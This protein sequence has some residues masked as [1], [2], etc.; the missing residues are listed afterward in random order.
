MDF[1]DTHVHL[2]L[3]D[4]L[5]YGWTSDIPALATGD[6]TL[7]DYAGLTAGK[8][9]AGWVFMETG[10][11]DADYK[12][13]ARLVSGL[14]GQSGLMGL[15]ASCRPED[16]AGFDDWLTECDGLHVH[17]Y[18]RILH[19]M[20]DDLSQTATFRRNVAKIGARGL[21]FDVCVLARQLPIALALAKA[22]PGQ[23]LVLD[24]CGVPDI[25]GGA[26]D[27]WARGIDALA[28]LPQ[29]HLKLSGISANC[30]PGQANLATLKPWVDHAIAAFGAKRVLWGG[31]W[32]VVNLGPGLPDW[33]D[34]SRALLADLSAEDQAQ[35]MQGTA[36]RVYRLS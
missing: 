5:G 26:F 18:R 12:A 24:H 21:P 9:V 19:V 25:A 2:I 29:M 1:I 22:C 31:D 17:G 34:L 3:R 4:R 32:P 11:D 23:S 35:I 14:L 28:A 7:A 6:F 15:I 20:P 8:G 33:I 16:D 36:K 27:D 10:V 13:E 30:P